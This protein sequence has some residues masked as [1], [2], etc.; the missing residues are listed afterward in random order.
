MIKSIIQGYLTLGTFWEETLK[1][2]YIQ[3][4]KQNDMWILEP[5]HLGNFWRKEAYLSN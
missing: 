3:R 2:E 4:S 1:L 5:C